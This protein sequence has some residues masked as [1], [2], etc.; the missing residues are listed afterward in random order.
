M[1]LDK[2]WSKTRHKKFGHFG[3]KS[4]TKK[5]TCGAWVG[6]PMIMANRVPFLLF[7]IRDL[8]LAWFFTKLHTCSLCPPNGRPDVAYAHECPTRCIIFVNGCWIFKLIFGQNSNGFTWKQKVFKA[9]QK[10]EK[11]AIRQHKHFLGLRK[12][13]FKSVY[14]FTHPTR[15]YKPNLFFFWHAKGFQ[16]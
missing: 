10:K 2:F 13:S 1:C 16:N 12:Q 9:F 5:N 11:K 15:K 3:R 6:H 4:V 8:Y 7:L 14:F